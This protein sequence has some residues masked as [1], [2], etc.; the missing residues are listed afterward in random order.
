ME[1]R[2]QVVTNLS[3]VVL[4]LA[5]YRNDHGKYPVKLANLAPRYLGQL[6]KDLFVGKDFQY[7]IKVK[8]Y[9]LY[10]VGWDRKDNGGRDDGKDI[11]IR[12]T[13]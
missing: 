3:Q 12:I 6:P 7:V 8:G 10:S 4:A 11:V 13:N 5:A 1:M 9:L 2:E